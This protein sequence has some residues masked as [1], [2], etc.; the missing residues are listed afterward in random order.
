MPSSIR[1]DMVDGGRYVRLALPVPVLEREIYQRALSRDE[2]E[3]RDDQYEY[4]YGI[5]FRG[6]VRRGAVRKRDFRHRSFSG[7]PQAIGT[8]K[9]SPG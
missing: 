6:D 7:V 3:R 9:G 1:F 4:E 2:K 8:R 5:D